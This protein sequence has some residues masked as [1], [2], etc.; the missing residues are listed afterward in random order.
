MHGVT[1]TMRHLGLHDWQGRQ[2]F[3]E[4]LQVAADLLPRALI[5]GG[6]DSSRRKA[7]DMQ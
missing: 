4:R 1:L 3:G 6:W 7:V 5:A 2:V